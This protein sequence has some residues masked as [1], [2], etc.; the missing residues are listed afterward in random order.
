MILKTKTPALANYHEWSENYFM[1][2]L[3]FLSL[4]CIFACFAS[5]VVL[6]TIP[7]GQ[8]S[9]NILVASTG[10]AHAASREL[11]CSR[12]AHAPQ[13][14]CA[15]LEKYCTASHVSHRKKGLA[16]K[17]R[18]THGYTPRLL[19]PALRQRPAGNRLVILCITSESR[20]LMMCTNKN[21]V[22]S[23]FSCSVPTKI[24]VLCQLDAA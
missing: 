17:T 3:N 24:Q 6:I 2:F 13:D 21:K 8:T 18:R 4:V 12:T 5:T 15:L 9:W 23:I 22:L 11:L 7:V 19:P 14:T 20:R 10:T 1:Y 16:R